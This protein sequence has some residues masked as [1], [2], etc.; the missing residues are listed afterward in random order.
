MEN[1]ENLVE[2]YLSQVKAGTAPDIKSYIAAHPGY[3]ETL[4]DLLPLLLEM[5]SIG[6]VATPTLDAL[7][8]PLPFQLTDEYTLVRMVGF[9]GMGTVFEAQQK[10]L[11]RQCI[12]KLISQ[13]VSE[14]DP[15]HL[16]FMR[17]ARIIAF[18]H[19]RHIIKVFNAGYAH[20]FSYYAMEYIDGQGLDTQSFT[21]YRTVAKLALQAA[22]AIAYAHQY[23]VTHRDLKPSNI[24]IDKD[25]FIHV[26]DFGLAI[27]KDSDDI[28]LPNRVDGGT[29]RY[30]A[31]EAKK[32]CFTLHTDQYAFGISLYELLAAVNRGPANQLSLNWKRTKTGALPS[33]PAAPKDL[34][35]IAQKCAHLDPKKR[36]AT[37]EDVILDLNRYLSGEPVSA[38][39]QSSRELLTMW[40]KRKPT[41]ATLTGIVILLTSIIL[42]A[43]GIFIHI[44]L[45][46]LDEVTKSKE[47]ALQSQRITAQ[48][49]E[50]ALKSQRETA[51]ALEQLK[52]SQNETAEAL[53]L[54]DK[55]LTHILVHIDRS[56]TSRST[57]RLLSTLLPYY[58]NIS[59]KQLLP[60][61][62]ISKAKII[63]GLNALNIGDVVMAEQLFR[64][65]WELHPTAHVGNLLID[66][67]FAQGK[68][69][70][71]LSLAYCLVNRY[72]LNPDDDKIAYE[73]VHALTHLPS[74]QGQDSLKL[75]LEILSR[76]YKKDPNN[77]DYRLSII[78]L[79]TRHKLEDFDELLSH[80]IQ[81]ISLEELH[82]I[83]ISHPENPRYLIAFLDHLSHRL[84]SKKPLTKQE[85]KF[86]NKGL[87]LSDERVRTWSEDSRILLA[88][89][90]LWQNYLMRLRRD[91]NK[92]LARLYDATKHFVVF[93]AIYEDSYFAND[94]RIAFIHY[95]FEA[96]EVAQWAGDEYRAERIREQIRQSAERYHGDGKKAVQERLKQITPQSPST[97]SMPL[98]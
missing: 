82:D 3:E 22:E 5:E 49:R 52:Q 51:Q 30:L 70:D 10:S 80:Q 76:L 44:L 65:E 67:L 19:H 18:L 46:S 7:N 25:G 14:S 21:D 61:E 98:K 81:A 47:A 37:M 24:F 20:N 39:E 79:M 94:I 64:E 85:E 28:M 54:A 83:Y 32:A 33:L 1:I 92:R 13:R 86:L 96:F 93:N 8:I 88:S 75:A 74:Y 9:G 35:A 41:T 34:E 38:R 45:H 40:A 4:G 95:L 91:N 43:G 11:N 84:I 27:L 6:Q 68:D 31:P 48:N 26:G 42:I 58:E 36:Y 56:P 15:R 50:V 12:I 87:Q 53:D 59:Q 62:Q 89:I 71:A 77:P 66:T 29:F 23:K 90:T 16:N 69:K 97:P 55:T 63:K 73:V 72:G 2:T 57:E 78:T 60:Q 17:E